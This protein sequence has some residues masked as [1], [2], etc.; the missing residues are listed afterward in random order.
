[1]HNK[2]LIVLAALVLSALLVS[3]CTTAEPEQVVVTIEV[4]GP[5]GET[6][7]I[8]ATP[9][10]GTGMET[11]IYLDDQHEYC[12]QQT[13]GRIYPLPAPFSLPIERED[14]A[15]KNGGQWP[16]FLMP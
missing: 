14:D 16:P 2:K 10:P 11:I 3:A 12:V 15:K 6:M 7:I 9:E 4:E 5:E 1:M 13:S 8:T